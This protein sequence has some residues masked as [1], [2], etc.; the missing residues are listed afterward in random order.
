VDLGTVVHDR[1]ENRRRTEAVGR[2]IGLLH[3]LDRAGIGVP[4]ARRLVREE[5]RDRKLLQ[6]VQQ[7]VG[8]PRCVDAKF[9]DLRDTVRDAHDHGRHER[10][11]CVLVALRGL[12]RVGLLERLRVEA[13]GLVLLI[14]LGEVLLPALQGIQRP[15]LRVRADDEGW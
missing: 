1:T 4:R 10:G 2:V 14:L 9:L 5:L 7:V 6:V 15:L 13:Q 8:K 3:H 11:I 12:P